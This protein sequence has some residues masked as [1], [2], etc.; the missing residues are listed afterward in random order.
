MPGITSLKA[1]NSG[2]C[3]S[4]LANYFPSYFQDPQPQDVSEGRGWIVSRHTETTQWVLGRKFSPLAPNRSQ[5]S[6][7][8]FLQIFYGKMHPE[9]RVWAN[10]NSSSWKGAVWRHSWYGYHFRCCLVRLL[11]MSRRGYVPLKSNLL[12]LFYLHLSLPSTGTDSSS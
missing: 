4:C 9:C 12:K 10:T 8:P 7:V 2:K 3:F 5:P 1:H 11:L 6:P